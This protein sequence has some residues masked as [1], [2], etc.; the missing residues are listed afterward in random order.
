MDCGGDGQFGGL[1]LLEL[2]QRQQMVVSRT[3]FRIGKD[4]VRA[5]NLP[6]SQR[7][8]RVAGL[9]VGMGTFDGP[10]ECGPK[11]FRVIARQ[12]AEQ[13]VKRVHRRSRCRISTSPTEIL[14]ANLAAEYA[15]TSFTAALRMLIQWGKKMTD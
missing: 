6:E 10:P 11:T 3:L 9:E 12:G 14:A 2:C 4:S 13:I 5:D 15:S 1:L 8:V 7:G